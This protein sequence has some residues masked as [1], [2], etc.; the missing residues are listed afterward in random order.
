MYRNSYGISSTSLSTCDMRSLQRH[1][2]PS[3]YSFCAQI[4]CQARHT[5]PIVALDH[6]HHDHQQNVDDKHQPP[7]KRPSPVSSLL[8]TSSMNSHRRLQSHS[9][10]T[11]HHHQEAAERSECF[12]L[13]PES[14]RTRIIWH[15]RRT[16]ASVSTKKYLQQRMLSVPTDALPLLSTTFFEGGCDGLCSGCCFGGDDVAAAANSSVAAATAVS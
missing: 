10:S 1:R 6:C 4:F 11:L 7:P 9:S 13:S 8:S 12:A 14:I 5:N 3:T 2:P 15:C 16:F